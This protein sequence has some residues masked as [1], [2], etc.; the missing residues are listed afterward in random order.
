LFSST[1]FKPIA[2]GPKFVTENAR[3][4]YRLVADRILSPGRRGIEAL[5]PGEGG[6]VSSEGKKVA[7]YRDDDGRLHAVST[8]CTHL[9]CQVAWNAAERSWDCPC[10]GSRFT[11]DGEILN[12]PA[13][14]PLSARPTPQQG[15]SPTQ[16]SA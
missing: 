8:R 1:R 12:G 11:P 13:T 2:G 5:G 7:G 16:R 15:T 10:H 6:I 3:V 9:G 14:T 4:G